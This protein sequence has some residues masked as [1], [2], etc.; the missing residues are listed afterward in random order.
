MNVKFKRTIAIAAAGAAIGLAASACTVSPSLPPTPQQSLVAALR[1]LPGVTA[2]VAGSV[3]YAED[4]YEQWVCVPGDKP[5][6]YSATQR[7][8]VFFVLYGYACDSTNPSADV[9]YFA[10]SVGGTIRTY[11]YTVK[12]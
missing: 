9:Q 4:G 12:R 8:I 10:N 6:Q 3:V 11:T 2:R 7:S 1:N 5:E